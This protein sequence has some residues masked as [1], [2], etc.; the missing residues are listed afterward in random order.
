MIFYVVFGIWVGILFMSFSPKD[1]KSFKLHL[2][3]VILI[4]AMTIISKVFP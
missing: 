3:S 1:S 4:T 2:A